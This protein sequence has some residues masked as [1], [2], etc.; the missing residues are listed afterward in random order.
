MKMKNSGPLVVL[1]ASLIWGCPNQGEAPKSGGSSAPLSPGTASTSTNTST[2]TKGPSIVHPPNDLPPPI[3]KRAP[4]QVRVDL[5]A[6]ELEGQLA[7]GT[8]YNYMT[9]NKQVPG[10]LIR[11]RVDDTVE[12]HLKNLTASQL[13]H[14]IDLHAVTGPGGGSVLTQAPPGQEKIVTFKVIKPGLFVYHCATAMVAEHITSGMYGMILVEPAD[15][16][17]P[18]DREFYVM[19]GELYTERPFAEYGLQKLSR[20][21]LLA[22][23]PE[24]LVFNGAVGA[25]RS[26]HPLRAKVGET[27]RIFFGVG[28]PNKISSFHI[29]GEHFDRLYNLASLASPPLKTVQTTLVPPGGA[30]IV[31][32]KLEVPGKYLLVDHALSRL[33]KGLLGFLQVEGPEHPELYREGESN[34][35]QPR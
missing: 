11:V 17:P 29:I 7:D 12:L 16:F 6:V 28:G 34:T 19:Q 9:F 14:S 21:K 22:E 26:E 3:R 33:E 4:Q 13:T 8:T 23:T 5:E 35:S 30:A 10:P 27:I 2:S 31:E 1:A 15:G 24:Y 32:L 25:L 20:K 18:V